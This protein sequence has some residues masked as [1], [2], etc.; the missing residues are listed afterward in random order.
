MGQLKR[1]CWDRKD[2]KDFINN[3]IKIINQIIMET[4]A[5]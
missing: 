2:R 1:Y 3:F 5:K 4:L